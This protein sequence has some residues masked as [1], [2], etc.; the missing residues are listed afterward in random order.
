[1]LKVGLVG[2]G[3]I[4]GIHIKSWDKMEDV[5]LV[6]LCDVSPEKLE[7]Y[8][9]KHHYQ[10]LDEM[11]DKENLDILDICLP[12]FLHTEA[13]LKALNRGIHVV[14]EKPISL[15][16]DDIPL[17]Y[18][19]AKKNGLC[20]FVALCVRFW[21]EYLVVKEI[22]DTGRYG[23]L[24]SGFMRR[25]NST[26][27]TSF[28]DWMKDEKRSG[29]V[30]FDL[31]IHDLDFMVYTFGTPT[32]GTVH[33]ATAPGQDYINVVYEYP[34]FFIGAESSWFSGR[35]PFAAEF[36]F[37]FEDAVVSLENGKFRIFENNGTVHDLS[38]KAEAE[39]GFVTIPE[40]NAYFEELRYFADCVKSGTF[41]D[42]VQPQE[43]ADVLTILKSL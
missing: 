22:Y 34:D 29:L 12:T 14:C 36:R 25:L 23:K 40:N 32:I 15:H 38:G 28:D 24:L 30:P 42:I 3:G 8:P 5:E 7:A 17:I 6:A 41:P 9:D 16:E 11:L 21:R 13:S 39:L 27:Q 19:T 43:L 4:S 35:F 26:P 20:Y 2:V 1:M 10:S 18:D 37:Q 31:H 33:R